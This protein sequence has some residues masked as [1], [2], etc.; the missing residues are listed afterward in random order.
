MEL[1]GGFYFV[2]MIK[3]GIDSLIMPLVSSRRQS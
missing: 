2:Q 3:N 1:L